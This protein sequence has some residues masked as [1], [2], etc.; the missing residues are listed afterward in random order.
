M[1]SNYLHE[2]KKRLSEVESKE[3]K[4]DS[5]KG[6]YVFISTLCASTFLFSLLE[7]IFKFDSTARSI[8]FS[9]LIISFIGL[10]GWLVFFPLLKSY[11]AFAKH[12]H[13]KTAGKVG[14][15]F[16]E[17]KDE[18]TNTLQLVNEKSDNYSSQLVDAA[19]ERVYKRSQ[20][21]NFTE[22][23]DFNST[24]K[25]LRAAVIV[26]GTAIFIFIVFPGLSSAAYRIINY[27]QTFT[28]PP[29]FIFEIKPGNVEITKGNNAE[30]IIKAIGE[31]PSQIIFSMKSEEQTEFVEKKLE[32]DSLGNFN[33]EAAAVKNS[34]EYFAEAE[35]IESDVYKISVI[36]RPVITNFE[37]EI[38]PP[39]YSKLPS[40]IQKDNGSIITLA[41]SRVKI[42]INSS[43]ELLD[44]AIEFSDNTN[45]SMNINYESASA[46]FNVRNE[47]GY[48]I[49]IKDVY[50][51]SNINPITYSIKILADEPPSIAMISPN[52][53]V[54]LGT[55]GKISLVIKIADDYG[56]SAL[57]L[58][59]KLSASKYRTASEE[60][61]S[62]SISI[63]KNSKEDEIY[64]VWDLASLVLAE[65]EA[66]SYYLEI[67]DND[68]V[69]GP[70]SAKTSLFT[71]QVPSIDE[72]FAQADNTQQDAAK[73]LAKTLEEAEKLNQEI[74]K[75][76]NDLKQNTREISWREKERTEKAA[77]KFKELTNK[78]EDVSQK[79]SEMQK[80]LMQN[81]LISEETLQKYNELQD[82]LDQF[83]SEELKEALKRMQESLQS[84][85]RDKVQMS[86]EELKANEEYFKKSIER[87]LNL[88]KR[89]QA[90]Q[91]VDELIKR[92]ED[93]SEK[94]DELKNKTEQNNLNEKNKRDELSK[95]QNDLSSNLENMKEEIE[96][97]SEKMNELSDMPK[98]EMEK[99]LKEFEKQ[100]NEQL[101]QDAQ[102][103]LQQ[104]QKNKALQNQQQ[105]SQNMQ[106]MKNQL[107]SLQSAM[108][109]K[110][111]MQ[112]F[113]EMIK[114][115]D[116]L[117][118]LSKE[119]EALKNST[120]KQSPTSPELR[121]NSRMQSNLQS[122]L[123]RIL[124]NMGSLSQKSFAITP[125]MGKAL[126][127]AYSQMQQ[128]IGAMQNQNT[129][130]AAQLQSK[131]MSHL[132]EA[133][134]L[135]KGGMDQMMSGGQGGGMMSL[136]Q[137][138]QQMAQQQMNL[139]QLTQMMNQGQ[140]TQQMMAQM[141]RLAQQQ[142]TIRKSL[143][144]LNSEA[145]ESGE[146]KRLAANLEKILNEMK[147]VVTNLQTQ[148]LD[149]EL[150]KQ[151]ERILSRLLDAQRSINE[152]DFEKDRKSD[153]GK[154]IPRTSP[155][156][157]I[158]STDEGK[159]K[160][161]DE[162]MK[163]IREGYKKDYEELIRKYLE[164]LQK[165]E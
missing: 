135:V 158:L 152:R 21:I 103:N 124:Q 142:E 114:I 144:E 143:E 30:I 132:N 118:T 123:S 98:E 53:N 56:F 71:I 77:D 35:G 13:L 22:A 24:K 129:P 81:N 140:M 18:L 51:F 68:N 72:L 11:F 127:E 14:N 45:K 50:G 42:K 115:L 155:P 99:L 36:N 120:N 59:Y 60:F 55:D 2:I 137:Q 34:F 76:G 147:E 44:A 163:A 146:S 43:R 20:N 7:A 33:F 80:E 109:Q 15:K 156:D 128:S 66:L 10:L 161:K 104:M 82:L 29:K 89:I 126:G 157:L 112:T 162:L 102:Q 48:K 26:L 107:Q 130:L 145:R 4:R 92:T 95:R 54:K 108:Q 117:V 57:N 47:S 136:M 93:I 149:D 150:V 83:N 101:S 133:A 148:K 46:E 32:P 139:N 90:E 63:N 79:L 69:N 111:Q 64:Y 37:A 131:A 159:D 58:N 62:I 160:L 105:L 1:N 119:Q 85:M 25:Y 70:K 23:V 49:L 110:N 39:S 84:M 16:H 106:S 141:Q 17:I 165:H 6:F 12:D 40:L 41:G 122:S 134:N 78:I 27:N 121:E 8:I 86:L 116:D 125:E 74:Q 52:E 100:N 94:L 5:L 91:K 151:Q 138:L 9:F 97:L 154:N 38:I 73:D 28:P 61:T 164:E 31:Q 19:F 113:Y 153:T 75:I 65:G 87:T 3:N 88:L 67:F 96:K